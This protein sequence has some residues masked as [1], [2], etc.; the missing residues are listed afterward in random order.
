MDNIDIDEIT[1]FIGHRFRSFGGGQESP[2]NPVAAALKDRP[3]QFAAGVDIRSVVEA[4]VNIA[5]VLIS[6]KEIINQGNQ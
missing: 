3:L 6:E 5:E 2:N 1:E 4:I